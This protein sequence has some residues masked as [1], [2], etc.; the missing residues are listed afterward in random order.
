MKSKREFHCRTDISEFIK[1]K[2]LKTKVVTADKRLTC[3]H[4]VEWQ[5]Y[6]AHDTVGNVNKTFGICAFCGC[7][8]KNAEI[9]LLQSLIKDGSKVSP[10]CG[11]THCPRLK[12]K[13]NFK[14]GW[15]VKKKQERKRKASG[16]RPN[17]KVKKSKQDRK[18]KPSVP[19]ANPKAKKKKIEKPKT[20][21]T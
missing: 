13:A 10:C 14:D 2:D 9:E 11:K 1:D 15:T 16:A 17:S 4:R 5:Y 21:K 7:E 18:R 20:K 12:P 8:L 6:H 3:N 19:K